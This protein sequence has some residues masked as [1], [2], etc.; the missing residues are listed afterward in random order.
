MKI[1]RIIYQHRR[2]FMAVYECEGC[3]HQVEGKG[4]KEGANEAL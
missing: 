1:A 4:Y 3:G 2:D